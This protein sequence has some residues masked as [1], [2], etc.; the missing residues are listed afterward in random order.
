MPT[1]ADRDRRTARTDLA[2]RWGGLLR[3]A[4][5][6]ALISAVCIP[7]QVAVF[8]IWPPPLDGTTVDWFTLLREQRLAALVDLDLLLV[9]DNVLLIPVL[10]ALAIALRSTNRSV[11]LLAVTLGLTSVV[12]YLTTNPAVQMAG[13]SDQY[14]AAATEADRAV[15]AAA[16][17]AA[18]A[19]WQGTAF[20]AA[21]LLGSVAGILL[22]IVMLRGGGFSR[23]AALLAIVANAV[24]LGLYVP[25]VGVCIAV[26]S[27]VFLEVWYV[28]IGWHLHQLSRLDVEDGGRHDAR[29]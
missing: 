29:S 21:Y 12:L 4:A 15:I 24:G 28:L 17:A 13:L 18:L 9:V 11:V 22:G 19:T 16:G 1:T 27:V 20:Q 10:L 25:R 3:V 26:F 6:A 5:A 23:A 7:V 2:D 8:L 14:T